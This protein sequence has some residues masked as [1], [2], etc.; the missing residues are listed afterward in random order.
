LSTQ[1]GLAG[2]LRGEQGFEQG[3]AYEEKFHGAVVMGGVLFF[4]DFEDQYGPEPIEMPVV[5]YDLHTGELLWRRELIGING[6]ADK[7][8]FGQMFYWDSYNYHGVFSYLWTTSGSTWNA[9]DPATGRWE[10][11]MIN[12]PSGVNMDGPN[13]E[14]LRYLVDT[15]GN[16]AGDVQ[17]WN[18]SRVVSNAGSWRPQGEIYNCS[19]GESRNG[20]VEW[21]MTLAW[22]ADELPGSPYKYR[23]N[24]VLGTNFQRGS[25]TE[26]TAYMWLLDFDYTNG[27]SLVWNKTWSVPNGRMHI[28]VE[29]V[30]IMDDLFIVSSKETRQTWGFRLST[31]NQIWGPTPS[32]FYTDNW[33]HSSGNSWD[34]IAYGEGKVIAGNYG[35]TV[36]CYNA[37]DG[38]VLWTFN[39]TDPYV[40]TLHGNRWRFRPVAVTD[41]KLFI[42]NTEHNPRDPQPRGAPFICL[43]LTTGEEIWRLPY[44]AGE[45]STYDILA[46]STA[47][48]QNTYD[49]HVYVVSKGPSKTTTE[50]ETNGIA[51]GSYAVVS[52]TVMDVSPGTT[53]PEIAL[54]FPNGVPAIADANMNKWMTYVYNQF[55]RPADAMGVE[56]R[57]QVVDPAGNYAW[58]GTAQSDAYGK[59]AYSF[60]PQMKGTY[61][62]IA[63]FVGSN[64]YYG[65]QDT[66]YLIVG[67]APTQVSIPPYPGYQGPSASE[68]ANSV[69]ASLPDDATPEEVAQAVVN[70]MPEYPEQQEVTI[71]EYTMIDIV[72]IILVAIAIV[73]GIVSLMRKK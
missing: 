18:S 25:I 61:T 55:E 12:V 41:G 20:G 64:S 1:G 31:G 22:V 57:I 43:N 44:R 14:I 52:G 69:V 16:G 70:A 50:I 37:E 36:W 24:M 30:S 47:I 65:S 9:F 33:G 46:E 21:N 26:D 34:I 27:V 29:D 8:D 39:I 68:V 32:R 54:R 23:D 19:Y 10:Y 72:I 73:I 6:E 38:T 17:L 51:L 71:P 45:W 28:T 3:D 40:E 53:D 48:L 60:I 42:E 35:G 4:N 59:Y 66:T 49:Q 2:G 58:I 15:S 56:V 13:G 63:T 11:A 5:A 7:I 62:I 67:D